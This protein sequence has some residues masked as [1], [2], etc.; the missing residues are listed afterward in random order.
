M[1]N[2]SSTQQKIT[3]Y[4]LEVIAIYYL[5]SNLSDFLRNSRS[6]DMIFPSPCLY[7]LSSYLTSKTDEKAIF[8][9]FLQTLYDNGEIN[10]DIRQIKILLQNNL[11]Q[12]IN[13]KLENKKI[14][15]INFCEKN[16]ISQQQ[17]SCRSLKSICRFVI[18]MNVKQY[19]HDIKYLTLLPKINGQLK[20]FLIYQNQFAFE[21]YI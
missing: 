21:S 5:S 8:E 2:N 16:L 19:P 17:N 10:F 14:D 9:K 4:F 20:N 1:T 12:F 18:K 6:I 11:Y 7:S 15:F 3:G 13:K